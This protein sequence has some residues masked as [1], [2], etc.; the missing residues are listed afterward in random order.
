MV[1]HWGNWGNC[2]QHEAVISLALVIFEL[3][4]CMAFFDFDLRRFPL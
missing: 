2:L 1:P 4:L 3:K